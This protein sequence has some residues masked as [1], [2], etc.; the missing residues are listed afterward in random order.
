MR[1]TGKRL[2]KRGTHHGENGISIS[3]TVY[4]IHSCIVTFLTLAQEVNNGDE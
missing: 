3:E 4:I 2:V 1:M